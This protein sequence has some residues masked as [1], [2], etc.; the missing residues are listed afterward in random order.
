MRR[1]ETIFR[2]YFSLARS[3]YNNKLRTTNNKQQ[4]RRALVTVAEPLQGDHTSCSRHSVTHISIAAASMSDSSG[5]AR[6]KFRAHDVFQCPELDVRMKKYLVRLA[7]ET[8]NHLIRDTLDPNG[9]VDAR[10]DDDDGDALPH[11]DIDDN[12]DGQVDARAAAT[13]GLVWKKLTVVKG[14]QI[15]RGH[16]VVLAA[17]HAKDV[18]AAS[19][20]R[21]LS[22]VNAS[23][24]EFALL[25]KLD[26]NKKFAEHGL[27]FNPDLLDMTT[28]YALVQPSGDHPRRYVGIKWCL[29]QSP[30]KLFRDRDFCYLE[31]QKE[32]R[33]AKGRRG[34]VRSMHSI[35]MPCCPSLEKSHSIVRASMYRCGLTA[36]ESS[37]PGVLKVTY[38]VEMDLKG[39]FPELFQPSFIAQR[40]GTLAS[41]D[42]YLQQ[43]RL[44]SSPLLGDLDLPTAAAR[45]TTCHLCYRTFSVLRIRRVV[46]R[47]CGHG[48]CKSCSSVWELDIP[49]IGKKKVRICTVC[50][51][52]ARY[53]HVVPQRM[54][55]KPASH[56][57]RHHE[58]RSSGS[59]SAK[60]VPVSP[61]PP[62]A[63]HCVSPP[64]QPSTSAPNDFHH[65]RDYYPSSDVEPQHQQQYAGQQQQQ[66]Q[67]TPSAGRHTP[68]AMRPS[69]LS[70]HQDLEPPPSF[71]EDPLGQSYRT[72]FDVRD[73]SNDAL[74][75]EYTTQGLANVRETTDL[76]G[77]WDPRE[78]NQS[79]SMAS[80]ASY[81]ASQLPESFVEVDLPPS[82]RP[83]PSFRHDRRQ[84]RNSHNVRLSRDS[85][86]LQHVPSFDSSPRGS[87]DSY[88]APEHR[89]SDFSWEV[90]RRHSTHA[91]PSTT[92]SHAPPSQR[93]RSPVVHFGY[94]D[95]PKTPPPLSAHQPHHHQH[96]GHHGPRHRHLHTHRH[97]YQQQQPPPSSHLPPPPNPR[98]RQQSYPFT[99][100]PFELPPYQPQQP[101]VRATDVFPQ[102][103][104]RQQSTSDA[105]FPT[106]L[107]SRNFALEFFH[108]Q[109]RN[110]SK[111]RASIGA[112]STASHPPPPLRMQQQQRWHDVMAQPHAALFDRPSSLYSVETTRQS[113][114]PVQQLYE[115]HQQFVPHH[116]AP[117]SSS[118]A[119]SSLDSLPR[120]LD[121][122]AGEVIEYIETPEGE[123]VEQRLTRSG[124]PKP[125][126]PSSERGVD[127]D[128][129][130]DSPD[131]DI[132][133]EE[134]LHPGHCIDCGAQRV[135]RYGVI[136]STCTCELGGKRTSSG[137]VA[138]TRAFEPSA[139]SVET[140]L[141]P[142]SERAGRSDSD[143]DDDALAFVTERLAQQSL[144]TQS[145]KA[146]STYAA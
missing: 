25:F 64:P 41:I 112:S 17:D 102:Q 24:E 55:Y 107:G 144:Q 53:S 121:Q 26:S 45:K 38:T 117:P 28:L 21:G 35:K 51:A 40:I 116:A 5:S 60:D 31:C 97:P 76:T 100:D 1:I 109:Y 115:L 14:I 61:A 68:T 90:R 136:E 72:T 27:L 34:W 29:V 43:Q 62:V 118:S 32:F 48:V 131:S 36:V 18:A 65:L 54:S 122:T 46:C 30:S 91:R 103:R 93:S 49:V 78:D 69:R 16:D 74:F 99:N 23:V 2:P 15:L 87:Y 58:R 106:A 3:C 86:L 145:T 11:A 120:A 57:T 67:S 141:R 92:R 70:Y 143:G 6:A 47:K 75:D 108:E 133:E 140:A 137:A 111:P 79:V 37:K 73:T 59:S 44:S 130:D 9:D 142:K 4:Q 132:D 10:T 124:R 105:Q 125:E 104:Y 42:R 22:E 89:Q 127:D 128:D 56:P 33:D 80:P 94:H 85:I 119:S 101:S 88:T 50:S 139:E 134:L 12:D 83:Q 126:R 84:D 95:R 7:N 123:W 135:C 113:H 82:Q 146:L 96:H 66:R 110:S 8:A 13:N 114:P 63:V 39:H 98:R 138:T 77:M 20:L 71:Q 81:F 129:D 19:C 52:A